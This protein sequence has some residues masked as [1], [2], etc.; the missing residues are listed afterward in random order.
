MRSRLAGPYIEKGAKIK[1]EKAN[2]YSVQNLSRIIYRQG[3]VQETIK[4]Q[5]F[6]N[7]M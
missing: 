2:R 6:L 1:T 7:N 5:R 3:Q 4:S